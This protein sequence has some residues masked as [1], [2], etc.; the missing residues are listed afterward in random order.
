M[1]ATRARRV[2]TLALRSKAS[3]WRLLSFAE[4]APRPTFGRYRNIIPAI[5]QLLA[6]LFANPARRLLSKAEHAPF[7]GSRTAPFRA[8]QLRWASQRPANTPCSASCSALG[9]QTVGAV[10]ARRRRGAEGAL[11]QPKVEQEVCTG[12]A[13]SAKLSMRRLFNLR[14]NTPELSKRR[15]GFANN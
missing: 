11:V 10:G 2:Q 14:L 12:S 7:L 8:A 13:C 9:L 3:S 4:Q 5:G 6:W 1:L 15:A